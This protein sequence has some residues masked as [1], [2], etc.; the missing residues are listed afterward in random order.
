MFSYRFSYQVQDSSEF[1]HDLASLHDF[2]VFKQEGQRLYEVRLANFLTVRGRVY[3]FQESQTEQKSSSE[4]WEL[5]LGLLSDFKHTFSLDLFLRWL[6][7]D[8]F[9]KGVNQVLKQLRKHLYRVF[10]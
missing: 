9:V 5:R 3:H 10:N 1:I 4:G 2:T 8:G 6:T 7:L